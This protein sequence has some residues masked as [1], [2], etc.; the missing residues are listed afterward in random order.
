M[1]LEE[2]RRLRARADERVAEARARLDAA[3]E[4]LARTRS[5]TARAEQA[6]A[7]RAYRE[8]RRKHLGLVLLWA[9]AARRHEI[10]DALLENLTWNTDGTATLTLQGKAKPRTQDAMARG[11]PL[12][13]V[14]RTVV[15]VPDVARE[16][17]TWLI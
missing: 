10:L 14:P 5:P 11:D 1:R 9:T 12:K 16:L 15:L 3:R 6:R 13:K 4:R 17:V 8:W 2:W 7:W